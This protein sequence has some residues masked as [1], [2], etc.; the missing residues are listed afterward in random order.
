MNAHI[1]RRMEI[2]FWD[3]TI[4]TLTQNM[5]VR[6]LVQQAARAYQQSGIQMAVP[7][8]A[9]S[10]AVGLICGSVLF[11]VTALIW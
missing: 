11:I 3:F 6:R 2:A 7:Y 9:V 5:R 4:H 10:A 8:L 1:Y